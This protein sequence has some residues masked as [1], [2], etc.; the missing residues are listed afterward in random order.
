M[1]KKYIGGKQKFMGRPKQQKNLAV[2]SWIKA[3]VE[4]LRQDPEYQAWAEKLT[5]QSNAEKDFEAIRNGTYRPDVTRAEPRS[6]Q[7]A[8]KLAE[9]GV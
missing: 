1:M 7:L 8:E 5:K 3:H 2:Q 6:L 9:G 4:K